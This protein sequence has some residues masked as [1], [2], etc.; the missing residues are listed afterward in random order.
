MAGAFAA[1]VVVTF[2]AIGAL[3]YQAAAHRAGRAMVFTLDENAVTRHWPGHPDISIPFSEI[4]TLR[5]DGYWLAVVG[6]IPARKIIVLRTLDRFEELRNLLARYRAPAARR[7]PLN[8]RA[9]LPA[10]LA[11]AAWLVLF[12]ER[13]AGRSDPGPRRRAHDV[14]IR[15]GGALADASALRRS[16]AG[17]LR[18]GMPMARRA[19]CHPGAGPALLARDVGQ[20]ANSQR[21]NAGP[22]ATAS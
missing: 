10:G 5:D 2:L 13:P 6:G 14:G 7:P 11:A 19:R 17:C 18:R 3:L 4:R 15:L 20:G 1:L 9:Y 22:A 16:P 8:R 12:F 21:G